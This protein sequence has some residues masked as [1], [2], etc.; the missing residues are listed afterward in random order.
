MPEFKERENEKLKKDFSVELPE[1]KER[2][3]EKLKKDFSVELPEFKEREEDQNAFLID[4]YLEEVKRK[5]AIDRNWKVKT[6]YPLVFIQLK[7]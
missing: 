7:I 3:N 1:F 4:I 2:E 6:G 5:I